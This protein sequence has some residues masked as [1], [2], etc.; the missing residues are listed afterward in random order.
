MR[1]G[2]V[3]QLRVFV[4]KRSDRGRMARC[5]S[6][7]DTGLRHPRVLSKQTMSPGVKRAVVVMR[8]V[9]AQ[10]R[11]GDELAGQFLVGQFDGGFQL[12]PTVEPGFTG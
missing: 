6:G 9:V 7:P 8:V 11:E 3:Q 10:A 4:Q 2:V 12:M 1:P 5:R